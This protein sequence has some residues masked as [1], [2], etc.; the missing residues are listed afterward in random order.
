MNRYLKFG[1]PVA[2]ILATCV[3]LG[4]SSTKQSA[5][6]FKEIPELKNLNAQARARNLLVNGYVKE[7]SIISAGQTTTF[8]MV[9][10]EGQKDVGQSLKVVY[11]GNDLPDT[12][13]DH[14]QVLAGGQLGDDGVFRANKL[15][16][17]C[18]SKYEAA[19]PKLSASTSPANKI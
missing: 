7:G 4:V 5:E 1:I 8:T 11:K 18:A 17:K 19:P 9:E 3:W 10:H 14:A 12:F 6:Y 13:K 16:A 15:Q 2:A